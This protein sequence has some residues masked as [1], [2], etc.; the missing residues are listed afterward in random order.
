M[1]RYTKP[2]KLVPMLAAT[3]MLAGAMAAG[4][5]SRRSGNGGR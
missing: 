3:V 4:C 5:R 2:N 1:R